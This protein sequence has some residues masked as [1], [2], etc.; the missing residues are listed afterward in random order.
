M[1]L[2]AKRSVILRLFIMTILI[3]ISTIS[4]NAQN[5]AQNNSKAEKELVSI[6]QELMDA[7]GKGDKAVWQRH[8]DDNCMI[9]T[10]DGS[11][12]TKAQIIEEISPLPKGFT[13]S[14]EV[15]EPKVVVSGDTA[16]MKFVAKEREE[17]FG[18]LI[19]TKYIE[20]DTYI[21][22]GDNWKL[23]GSQIMEL[24]ADPSP[25]KLSNE[26]LKKYIGDYQL[27]ENIIYKVS[28]EGDKLYGQRG[29]RDKEELIPAA[30]GVFHRKGTRVLKIFAKDEKGEVIKML[31]R[32]NGNDLAWKKITARS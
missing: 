19:N 12:K 16:I 18:Q 13:G 23:I 15:I 9:T 8:L 24:S 6:A 1:Q 10:E 25:I 28:V 29:N 5:D 20:T 17:V 26:A 31:D 27:A 14:I 2:I 4:I 7:V 3:G 30:D 11:T 32:R 22:R 21:K